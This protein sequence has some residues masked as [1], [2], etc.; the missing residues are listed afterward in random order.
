MEQ[1]SHHGLQINLYRVL[2]DLR[3]PHRHPRP[4]LQLAAPPAQ[5]LD[6]HYAARL[7]DHYRRLCNFYPD[8]EPTS[9]TN[10]MVRHHHLFTSID[11]VVLTW[12]EQVLWVLH[13]R[14][15]SRHNLHRRHLLAHCRA[16]AVA[17]HC[18]DWGVYALCAVARRVGR[19]VD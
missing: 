11:L 16:A 9:L 5:L 3:P 6:L 17:R 12:K 13:H 4:H 15:V 19:R 2:H 1:N 7:D 8:S 14:R 10:S 18:H